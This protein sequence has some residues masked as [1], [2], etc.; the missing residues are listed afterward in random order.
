MKT[1][2]KILCRGLFLLAAAAVSLVTVAPAFAESNRGRIPGH[3]EQRLG[4]AACQAQLTL[5]GEFDLSVIVSLAEQWQHPQ[6]RYCAIYA[7]G[8]VADY[9]ATTPLLSMLN[10][11]DA[12]VRR[13][14][15]HSLG[16]I[17]DHRAVMPLIE[18]LCRVNEPV[19]VQSEAASALGKLGDP[20]ARRNPVLSDLAR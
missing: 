19:A 10:S 5:S 3:V 2:A 11:P 4:Q 8:E 6:V 12:H 15:A 18:L 17:G 13:A 1:W 7:L 20:R 16:K 9:R 14:A